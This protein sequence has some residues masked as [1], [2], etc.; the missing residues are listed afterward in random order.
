M[1]AHGKPNGVCDGVEMGP[2]E[3]PGSEPVFGRLD[4]VAT[5][6]QPKKT[7]A[8]TGSPRPAHAP[9]S[10]WVRH[11][12]D[13]WVVALVVLG[14][15]LGLAEVHALGPAGR[16][17]AAVVGELIGVA[18]VIVPFAL[19]ALGVALVR[20]RVE[21]DGVR[22]IWGIVLGVVSLSGLGDLAGGR[23]SIRATSS[24]L[25][26]AGGWLGVLTGGLPAHAF[27]AVGAVVLL[28]AILVIAIVVTTGVGLRTLIRATV[29]ATRRA[30]RALAHWWIRG[31]PR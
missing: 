13:V 16:S 7:P 17:L 21:L 29:H 30:W 12:R 19:I 2:V 4:V 5:A 27:G 3:S 26:R 25:G 20:E 11:R 1:R 31:R 22:L 28:I 15:L 9:P 10:L 6:R 23:P 24:Q 18:R 8:R 14:V